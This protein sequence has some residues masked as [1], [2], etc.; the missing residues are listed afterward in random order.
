MTTTS[1]TSGSSNTLASLLSGSLSGSN[2]S[3]SSTPA[4]IGG[5]IS[6]GPLDVTQLV[7]ELVA[8]DSQ[9]MQ[10]LQSQQSGVQA[11]LSAYGQ[12]QSALSSL[13]TSLTALKLGSAFTAA[14]AS[15]T[16]SG[17][18]AT[19]TGSPASGSY[20]VTVSSVAQAQA[21]ASSS[22]ANAS[23]VVGT[24]TLTIQLGTYNAKANT[25][26]AQSGSSPVNITINSNNDTLGGIAAAINS[27]G[28]GVT[29]SVVTDNSGSR[30]VVASS[31]TG[32]VNGFKLTVAD[33]DGNNTDM[34]GLSQIAFDPTAAAGAGQNLTLTQGAADAVYSINGLSL[35]S[36]TNSITTAISG[37]TLNLIQAPPVGSTLQAQVTIAPD[38]NAV[39]NSVN[40]FISAYNSLVNLESS[41]TSYDASSNTASVLTGQTPMFQ[42]SSQLRSIIGSQM[43]GVSG[44]SWL[45]DVGIDFQNDGTLSLNSTKFSAAVAS[46]PSAVSKLFS[47]AIGSGN[48][49]GFAVRLASSVESMLAPNGLLGATQTSLQ[50]TISTMGDQITAMQTQLNQEQQNLTAQYSQ[51]NADLV[52]AQQNQTALANELAGLPMANSLASLQLP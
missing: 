23:T 33:S 26:T 25:F 35:T 37:L 24:G 40:S 18:G 52:T 42:L 32:T 34:T 16:G 43:S 15:V 12:V 41:L 28:A 22:F 51:L 30:L 39:S 2:S 7:S 4:P 8:V 10:Q 20:S 46:N 14:Q 38:T 17:V 5:L 48:Q 9:P 29:A 36:S 6:T 45:A 50:S 11:Q 47:N 31:N 13:D 44:L 19:V 27:A 49:Q 3:G 1:S 21:A